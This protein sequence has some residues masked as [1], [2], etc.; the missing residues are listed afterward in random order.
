MPTKRELHDCEKFFLDPHSYWNPHC[1]FYERNKQ[2]MI[3]FE[4]NMSEPSLRS[5]DLVVFENENEDVM[6]ELFSTMALV[7]T[8]D[9][10]HNIDTNFSTVFAVPPYC[11]QYLN[12]S[13]YIVFC[14]AINLRG[15]ISKISSH[16]GS[17]NV[18][19]EP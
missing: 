2:L 8:S 13:S 4:G 18:S 9:W 19:S 5:N 12:P 10:E 3:H 14:K 15:D 11:D 17:C 6:S 7:T 1:Q 16:I